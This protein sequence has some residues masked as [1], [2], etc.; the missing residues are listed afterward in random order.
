MFSI[1]RVAHFLQTQLFPPDA[2][3]RAQTAYAATRANPQ[4]LPNAAHIVSRADAAEYIGETLAALS[5]GRPVF[6]FN[7]RWSETERN[8]AQTQTALPYT[9]AHAIH[10][11]TG[12]TSGRIRFIA[13]TESTLAA[14]AR[15]QAAIFNKHPNPAPSSTSTPP[16][17]DAVSPLPPWHVSGWMPVVRALATGG[18]LILCDGHFN[19]PQPLPLLSSSA[20]ARPAPFCMI[21]LVP[22][23]LYRLLERPDGPSWLRHFD[24][25]LMGGAPMPTE[26]LT[27]AH[28]ERLPLGL[29]Y[30]MTE[31]AAFVALLSPE[32]FLSDAFDPAAPPRGR[33]LSHARIQILA[34]NGVPL[35]DGQAGRVAIAAE[36][37]APA[38]GEPPSPARPPRLLTQDEGILQNGYL[39]ILGRLDRFIITGGE[40]VDPRRVEA[41]LQQSPTV[42]AALVVGEPDPE[43]GQR[44]VALIEGHHTPSA[45]VPEPSALSAFA[46]AKLAPYCVPK[47]WLI[48]PRLPFD[49]KGKL[50]HN[51]LSALLK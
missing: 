11:A 1:A 29:G 31:T 37:L 42:R 23:Q 33:V 21:S 44:V 35:P 16:Q 2:A 27:R 45:A 8:E 4:T 20:L 17:L 47:R 28:R 13:H 10:I 18:R 39:R 43:W 22:A 38:H 3:A 51:T 40:K 7:P 30:G 26:L 46:R 32:D 19:A 5:T 50:D 24:C 6:F 41:V 48:V 25:V 49:E 9:A 36:S 14:A 12:G 15:A 34:P